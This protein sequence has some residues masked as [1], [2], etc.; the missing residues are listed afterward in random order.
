[1]VKEVF[2]FLIRRLHMRILF[3]YKI[4]PCLRQRG[5]SRI[6]TAGGLMLTRGEQ[7]G[8]AKEKMEH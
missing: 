2:L 1:M 5:V 4:H 7:G 8:A 3:S 6:L